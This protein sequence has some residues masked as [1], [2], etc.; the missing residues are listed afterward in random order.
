MN[1]SRFGCVQED[2]QFEF[3]NSS[4]NWYT[5]AIVSNIV[6]RLT[7]KEKDSRLTKFSA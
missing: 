7:V 1:R 2:S 5:Q 3:E 6:N 4:L